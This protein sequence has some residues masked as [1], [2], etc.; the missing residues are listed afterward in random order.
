MKR[1]NIILGL[2]ILAQFSWAQSD[3]LSPAPEQDMPIVITGATA[4]LGNGT[5]IDN[6][7]I[8]FSKG[9]ISFV[10]RA[11]DWSGTDD[12]IMIDALKEKK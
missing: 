7:A 2:L 11:A 9:K 6:A 5:K 1:L 10:G 8:A 4:H 12:H 3:I